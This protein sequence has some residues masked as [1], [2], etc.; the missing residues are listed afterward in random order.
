MLYYYFSF[1]AVFA[2]GQ[3]AGRQGLQWKAHSTDLGGTR[4]CNRKPDPCGNAQN[5]LIH[6]A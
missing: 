6:I 4:T 5:L 2:L 3:P 1:M